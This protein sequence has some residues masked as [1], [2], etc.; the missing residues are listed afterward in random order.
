MDSCMYAAIGLQNWE[1][2]LNVKDDKQIC[3]KCRKKLS[4]K[5]THMHPISTTNQSIKA[6]KRMQG[7]LRK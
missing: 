4:F 3:S 1:I 2:W 5:E 7:E 6:F